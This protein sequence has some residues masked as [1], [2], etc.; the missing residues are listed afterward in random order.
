ME[1]GGSVH[2]KMRVCVIG[3][4]AA[5]LCAVRHLSSDLVHFEPAVF[6]LSDKVG[7]T[8]VYVDETG[9][10]DYG[11]PIHSSMYKNLRTN[12][13]TK[14]MNFPDYQIMN[15]TRPSCGTHQQ[16]LDYLNAYADHFAIRRFIQFNTIVECVQPIVNGNWRETTWRVTIR[17]LKTNIEEER[18]FDAI[19]VCNGHYAVPSVPKITG[20]ETFPGDAMHSHEYRKPDIYDGK[21]VIVLGA[22]PSGVDIGIEIASHANFVYLSHNGPRLE[23]PLLTNMSQVMGVESIDGDKFTLKDGTVL[24]ADALLYCTGYEFAFPF[25]HEECKVRVDD[26][27]VT[28][29]WKHLI[30]IEHPKMCLV[31]LPSRVIPFPL[32]HLQ[33]AFFLALLRGTIDLPS[34]E[35]MLVDT[36]PFSEKRHGHVLGN[37]QW[38]YNNQLAT[39]A[40][41]NTLPEFYENG[42]TEW[43]IQKTS[44]LLKYKDAEIVIEG[45][46]KTVRFVM[47]K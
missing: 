43:N 6:E 25:L 31:G 39:L 30:N 32:F 34:K 24:T 21:T 33:V 35:I 14:L 40:G 47:E 1:I 3:A 11:L 41:M 27:F 17:N 5:G 13:P 26:N 45:D 29:L 10:D 22:G 28:P 19:M 44:N 37:R 42:Y 16:I 46:G 38:K 7:G 20:I 9:K 15:Q 36:R 4:G 8:W 12:F 18:V 2:K 23:S